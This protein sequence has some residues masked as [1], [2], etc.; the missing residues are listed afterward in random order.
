MLFDCC[1][2]AAA[3]LS[4]MKAARY[5]GTARGRG[6]WPT[7][8]RPPPCS[9]QGV[10][11]ILPLAQIAAGRPR[12]PQRDTGQACGGKAEQDPTLWYE[13][14]MP[15]QGG[16]LPF[17]LASGT[18][19]VRHNQTFRALRVFARYGTFERAFAAL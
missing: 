18:S 8:P 3:D 2:V 1:V 7:A 4:R 9:L 17:E 6:T 14:R 11:A 5:P 10:F 12:A 19:K 15:A 13:R 16:T